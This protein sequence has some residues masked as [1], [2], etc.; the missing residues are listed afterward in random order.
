MMTTTAAT[1]KPTLAPVER[2]ETQNVALFWL[3]FGFPFP[4][5][6]LEFGDPVFV[7]VAV[8]AAPLVV[9]IVVIAPFFKVLVIVLCAP[10]PVGPTTVTAAPFCAVGVAINE[11]ATT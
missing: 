11:E 2:G 4:I 9:V 7:A 10:P 1:P 5:L 6:G 3:L 8:A